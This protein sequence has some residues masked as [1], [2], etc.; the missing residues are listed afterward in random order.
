MGKSQ[1]T[2]E[3]QVLLAIVTSLLIALRLHQMFDDTPPQDDK[4][5]R[6]QDK[7]QAARYRDPDGTDRPPLDDAAVPLHDQA[8]PAGLTPRSELF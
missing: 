1:V 8:Q 6:K 4:A 7:R 3:N 2:I 5:L